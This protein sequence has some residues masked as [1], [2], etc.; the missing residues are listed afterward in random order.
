MVS[1]EPIVLT[2]I[3]TIQLG[4]FVDIVGSV[5]VERV[6]TGQT[7]SGHFDSAFCH[8]LFIKFRQAARLRHSFN[9]FSKKI[10]IFKLF[11]ITLCL[12]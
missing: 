4:C 10:D 8:K 12:K 7:S 6:P 1:A 11:H 3:G 5:D 2:S 9:I